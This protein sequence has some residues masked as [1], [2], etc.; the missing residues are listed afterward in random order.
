[1]SRRKIYEGLPLPEFLRPAVPHGTVLEVDAV[2]KHFGGIRAVSDASLTVR[3]GEIHALIGPNGAGKTTLFNLVSGM[4]FPDG[5][6]VRL[7]GVDIQ[8]HARRTGSAARVS[9]ARSRS[10]TSSA[11]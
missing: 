10:P 4:F 6:T 8:G 3:A 9:R 11:V 7:L 2:S 5:G 1:M